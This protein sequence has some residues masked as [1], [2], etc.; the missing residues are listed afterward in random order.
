[1][2]GAFRLVNRINQMLDQRPLSD[3]LTGTARR[4]TVSLG[5]AT[6]HPADTELS[7]IEA[8]DDALYE[9]KHN[10]RNGGLQ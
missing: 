7:L 6:A 1:M 4:A 2:E 9:A 10:G 8:A 5:V 3:D